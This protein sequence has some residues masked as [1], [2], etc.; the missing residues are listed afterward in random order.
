MEIATRIQTSIL[1]R[2]FEVTGMHVA[3]CM[4]PA[5]EVGGDYYDV[6]PIAGGCWIGIGD[7]AGHG[8]AAGLEMLMVQSVVAALVR[9]A[10]GA[11]PR[12]HVCVLNHVIHDNIRNRLHQDE[13]VTLTLLRCVGGTVTFAGA[14]EDIVVLRRGAGRC[15]RV[16]TPGTWLGG[17]RDVSRATV[18]TTLELGDGDVMVLYSD[19]VTEARDR[20][21]RMFGVER[22]CAAVE[23]HADEGVDVILDR[24]IA[25]VRA[26]QHGQTDDISVVVVRRTAV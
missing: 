14:H 9:E 12:D 19:G 24:I 3:A 17:M 11:A 10:P 1:P 18:D 5:T 7:V 6:L 13:H 4:I 25:D 26:W 15:E 20:E 23:R 2:T 16:A 8:L 22:L 21:G